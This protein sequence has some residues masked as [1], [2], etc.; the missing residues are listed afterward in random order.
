MNGPRQRP[1]SASFEIPDLDLPPPMPRASQTKLAAVRPESVERPSALAEAP[2]DLFSELPG[3]AL[4]LDLGMPISSALESGERPHEVAGRAGFALESKLPELR[5]ITVAPEGRANWP[6]GVTPSRQPLEFDWNQVRALADYGEPSSL[7]PMNVF[8]ALRVASQQRRLKRE[9]RRYEAEL[10]IAEAARDDRLAELGHSVR[11]EIE[12]SETYQRLLQP[13]RDVETSGSEQRQVVQ[14]GEAEQNA[15][16]RTLDAEIAV[17]QQEVERDAHALAE[18][19]KICD[20]REQALLRL[21]ARHKRAFIEL[22]ALEQRGAPASEGER[23]VREQ[24][25]LEPELE[26]AR[27]AFQATHAEREARSA[28]MR[29]ARYRIGEV[30]RKKRDVHARFQKRF[31][32]GGGERKETELRRRQILAELGRAVLAARGGVPVDPARLE[33]LRS[34]DAQVA[35]ALNASELRLRA[36]DAC[37]RDKLSQGYS[38]LLGI[39]SALVAL[40][41][42]RLL[43]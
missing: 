3:P 24:R 21:E 40:G 38:W 32:S 41:C 4:D 30:E 36:L 43:R 11:A 39:A 33:A 20:A 22:R 37:D 25:A 23:V 12:H 26:A 2:K 9:L 13:L 6:S 19:Q 15:E 5:G 34:S 31:D 28:A 29:D 42:Y 1:Q 35:K 16:L 27:S 17:I 7:G 8:Y 18:L 10:A 14:A